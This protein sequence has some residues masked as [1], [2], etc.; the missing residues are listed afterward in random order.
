MTL[1]YYRR[2]RSSHGKICSSKAFRLSAVL[3]L[4]AAQCMAV[5]HAAEHLSHASSELC[6]LFEAV[7]NHDGAAV[8]DVDPILLQGSR[9]DYL[10]LP[11]ELIN[12]ALYLPYLV[13]AP[14]SI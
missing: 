6:T 10:L 3:I 12:T 1:M 7:E 5:V 8:I 4:L 14:P 2:M 13:R 11:P 9:D